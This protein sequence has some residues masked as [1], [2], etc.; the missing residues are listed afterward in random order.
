MLWVQ[1]NH[2]GS[3]GLLR[4]VVSWLEGGWQIPEYGSTIVWE[5]L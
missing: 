4:P 1:T 3:D 5:E 2:S